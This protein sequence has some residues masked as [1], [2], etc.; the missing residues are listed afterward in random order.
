MDIKISKYERPLVEPD[1]VR[2][3]R[4]I[5]DIHPGVKH[6][7]YQGRV[8]DIVVDKSIALVTINMWLERDIPMQITYS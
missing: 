5:I 3:R 8:E 6:P 4:L 7:T 2:A 1:N